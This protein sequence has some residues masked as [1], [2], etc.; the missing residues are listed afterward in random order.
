M[1]KVLFLCTGNY[2]RSRFAEVLFNWLAK[3][4]GLDW[5]ADSR[6]FAPDVRNVGPISPHS[7]KDL[8]RRGIP[9]E[10]FCRDPKRV[11]E[12]DFLES[13]VIIALKRGEHHSMMMNSFPTWIERVEFWNVH[14]LD[15]AAP[16]QTIADLEMQVTALVKRLNT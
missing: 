11:E 8:T 12:Q 6:G 5:V 3:R 1:K 7:F 10:S 4:H 14:D 15:C 16:E 9:P 13:N 2:Y